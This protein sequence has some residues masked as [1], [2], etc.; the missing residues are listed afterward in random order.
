MR[1]GITVLDTQPPVR[2]G[3]YSV[4][5]E[6]NLIDGQ[7]F[8]GNVEADVVDWRI[9]IN[10]TALVAYSSGWFLVNATRTWFSIVI[11]TGCL[12]VPF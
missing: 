9:G 7:P 3:E 4:D 6:P 1:F 12:L 10:C 8:D 2:S 11:E 5:K